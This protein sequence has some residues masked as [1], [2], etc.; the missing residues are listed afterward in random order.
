MQRL[1]GDCKQTRRVVG[2]AMLAYAVAGL[3]A[4]VA[5]P[6]PA[7]AAV[8]DE[9]FD[10]GY[11]IVA[12]TTL[13]GSF[14]G[15][16]RQQRLTF[17]DGSV[18]ACARNSSQT[19]YE[20]RVYILALRGE[21]PS[22]VLV[23]SRVQSGQLLRLRSRDYAVPLRMNADP[24]TEP[25]PVPSVALQPTGPVPSINTVTQQQDEPLSEQQA[26]LPEPPP[27]NSSKR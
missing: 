21:R 11:T 2:R 6:P 25:P 14:T 26:R 20:P 18:F 3:V 8:L 22:V 1:L 27:K 12:A 23:G 5:A 19:A 16:A 17:A 10:R 4:T 15:C 9:F 7:R 24:L 13:P